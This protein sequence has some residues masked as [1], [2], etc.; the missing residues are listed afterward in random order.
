M[1]ELNRVHG[2]RSIETL[3]VTKEDIETAIGTLASTSASGPDGVPA[4]FL[5]HCKNE[6]SLPLAILWQESLNAGVVPQDLKSGCI[7]PVHKGG[8]KSL[9]KN[10][11]PITLT[12]HI[13]KIF[14]KLLVRVLV[15]YM[16]VAGLFNDRQHGFRQKR[17]CLSLL[18][19]HHQ[20]IVQC[21][22]NGEEVPV[23]Y[24]DFCKAFDIVDHR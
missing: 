23:V 12:S 13:I 1:D 8:D 17:S 14:E 20:L 11:R 5:K 19:E 3:T 21:M 15:D 10:Y 9:P 22:E 2:P 6:V 4:V 16:N 18:L 7:V 24:L